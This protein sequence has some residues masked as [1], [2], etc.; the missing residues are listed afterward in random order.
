MLCRRVGPEVVHLNFRFLQKC[1]FWNGSGSFEANFL[2]PEFPDPELTSGSE[3]LVS[4]LIQ[5]SWMNKREPFRRIRIRILILF[6][7]FF[8]IRTTYGLGHRKDIY[9]PVT[10][11]VFRICIGYTR[12]RMRVRI[13]HLEPTQIRIGTRIPV[14]YE[15]SFRRKGTGISV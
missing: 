13:Q 2:D 5:R 1:R 14:K 15:P 11:Q 9:L 3:T 8:W 12:I 6:E 4:T 7:K 10:G